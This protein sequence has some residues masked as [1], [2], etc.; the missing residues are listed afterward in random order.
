MGAGL[1]PECG[2]GMEKVDKPIQDVKVIE[3]IFGGVDPVTLRSGNTAG[4]GG[5]EQ[6]CFVEAPGS[7]FLEQRL[8]RW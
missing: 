8:D 5:C 3:I 7:D 1:R 2:I 6:Q 4:Q